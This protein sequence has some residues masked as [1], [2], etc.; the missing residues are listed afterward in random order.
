MAMNYFKLLSNRRLGALLMFCAI[1]PAYAVDYKVTNLFSGAA[2]AINNLDQ[3]VGTNGERGRL[4]AYF[5]ANGATRILGAGAA[6][7]I[8]N[9]SEVVGFDG[10]DASSVRA[11]LWV[12]SSTTDL[13]YGLATH[14]NEA[15]TI[16]GDGPLCCA[17]VLRNNGAPIDLDGHMPAG[18]NNSGQMLGLKEA[19]PVPPNQWWG[20]DSYRYNGSTWELLWQGG[21]AWSMNDA[22][23][24]VGSRDDHAVVWHNGVVTDLG[25]GTAVSI[26]NQGQVA[27]NQ[28]GHAKI[29]QKGVMIDLGIGDI[30]DINDHG[31]AVGT[32]YDANGSYAALWN[33]TLAV[34]EPASYGM[35]LAGL[36]LLGVAA[37]RKN[38][39]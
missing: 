18:L 38:I 15:G 28:N 9:K 5:W 31:W 19:P 22:G 20:F 36:A 2:H 27:L 11:M 8:N 14:I 12:G 24:V 16:L 7:D 30:S 13:G 29:W 34:P 21:A 26:N 33:P 17:S 35:L 3:V 4:Q 6:L 10:G 25:E 32:G 23:D 39:V 1:A 37:R